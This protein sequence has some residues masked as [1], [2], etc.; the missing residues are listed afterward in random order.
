M[1]LNMSS[2]NCQSFCVCLLWVGLTHWGRVTH[3]CFRKLTI[4]GS[5]NGLSPGR[6]PA[7]IWTNTEYCQ[8][9]P[10]EQTSV[11]FSVKFIYFHWENAFENVVHKWRPFC[12]GLNVLSNMGLMMMMM[13]T[14]KM[15][16][17]STCGASWTVSLAKYISPHRPIWST[18]SAAKIWGETM[19]HIAV[20]GSRTWHDP[21]TKPIAMKYTRVLIIYI[22]M[23][24]D[25]HIV[26]ENA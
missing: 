6:R 14:M 2:V 23:M 15:R 26:I 7:I 13:M 1:H 3:I 5:D 11:K 4:I 20:G 24:W 8:L 25:I 19:P 16:W 21:R 18:C 12:F 10:W 9:D 17:W 22:S